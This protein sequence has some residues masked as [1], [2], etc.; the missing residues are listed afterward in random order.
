MAVKAEVAMAAAMA[1]GETVVVME[2]EVKEVAKAV[3]ATVAGKAEAAMVVGTEVGETAAGRAAVL[4]AAATE[5]E[6][7]AVGKAEAA[8][9]VPMHHRGLGDASRRPRALES[10]ARAHEGKQ[11][12]RAEPDGQAA[13]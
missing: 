5:V 3:V 12:L 10:A 11:V 8:M 6:V 2:V 7:R 13:A 9:V 4:R 1:V